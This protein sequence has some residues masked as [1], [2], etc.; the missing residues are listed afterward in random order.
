M[1]GSQNDAPLIGLLRYIVLP[2]SVKP[3]K[4]LAANIK[5]IANQPVKKPGTIARTGHLTNCKILSTVWAIVNE[6]VSMRI[7]SLARLRGPSL[8]S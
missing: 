4:D 1:I 6:E 7:A 8:R 5:N 2:V 3:E